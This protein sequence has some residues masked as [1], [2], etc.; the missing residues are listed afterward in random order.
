MR[1]VLAASVVA[2]TPRCCFFGRR[3]MGVAGR[4]VSLLLRGTGI[5][6]AGATLPAGAASVRYPTPE[7]GHVRADAR[8]R[9][10]PSLARHAAGLLCR[11]AAAQQ[12][13]PLPGRPAADRGDRRRHAGC[14]RRR[15]RPPAARP[16]RR[17]CGEPACV[18]ARR[19]RSPRPTWTRA[20]DRCWCGAGRAAAAA[21]SA[22]TTGPSNSSRPGSRRAS[23]C[24]SGR[25]CASSTVRRAGGRG[26]P[27][28]RARSFGAWLGTP[29]CGGASR[30][31]SCA[32]RT[33]S[34][35]RARA[36]R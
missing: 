19:S 32:T 1:S 17:G 22:W 16:D 27:P 20:A 35:W 7:D 13:D 3:P 21:R 11:P 30:R 8:C 10:P 15:A 36:C 9:R 31:I 18:S 4:D 33:P 6:D 12:G 23:S 2:W 28:R 5:G 34:R 29:A 24:R 25:C 26:R 14:W